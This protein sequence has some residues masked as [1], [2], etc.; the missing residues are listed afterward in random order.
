MR[1]TD[2]LRSNP[3]LRNENREAGLVPLRVLEMRRPRRGEFSVVALKTP[4]TCN[5]PFVIDVFGEMPPNSEPAGDIYD[6]IL[7]ARVES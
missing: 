1:N 3:G 7:R 4:V 6:Y 5:P 2:H